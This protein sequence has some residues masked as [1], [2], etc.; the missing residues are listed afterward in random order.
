MIMAKRLNLLFLI[1]AF[2]FGLQSCGNQPATIVV[3]SWQSI[4]CS[5]NG[6]KVAACDSYRVYLSSDYGQSW[7]AVTE[8][9]RMK[10]VAMSSDGSVLVAWPQIG[11][12]YVS[13][14]A[15]KTWVARYGTKDSGWDN[16]IVSPDGSTI[17]GY[18]GTLGSFM[19]TDRGAS[20]TE[21]AEPSRCKAGCFAQNGSTIFIADGIYLYRSISAGAAWTKQPFVTG[22][23]PDEVICS[24]DGSTVVCAA[25]NDSYIFVS[26]NAGASWTQVGVKDDWL[27][28]SSS[29]DCRTIIA[30]SDLNQ[31][32]VY[33]SSNKGATWSSVIA[34]GARAWTDTAASSD[35]TRL[36]ACSEGNNGTIFRSENGGS[37]WTDCTPD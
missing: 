24:S 7:Q 19:S 18:A 2:V 13:T 27:D 9:L 11:Y 22:A 4:C 15:G 16:A 33:V 29:S 20:W 26:T 1:A 31:G 25:G 35:G 32:Y 23:S 34:I 28:L 17:I 5:S 10:G 6:Q 12:L 14:D 8:D 3:H 30:C 36:L 37:T 21:L